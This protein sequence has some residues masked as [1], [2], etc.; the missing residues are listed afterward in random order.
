MS[1]RISF[2][3]FLCQIWVA[4]TA[5]AYAAADE[6]LQRADNLFQRGEYAEAISRYEDLLQD[7]ETQIDAQLGLAR[8]FLQKGEYERAR[9][10]C[11]QILSNVPAQPEALTFLGLTLKHTGHYKEARA[12]FERVVSTHPDHLAARLQLGIMQWQWGQKAEARRTLQH[13]IAAYQ[14][15]RRLSPK[16]IGLVA[17][18]CIYLERFR[19]ANSLFFEATKADPELWQALLPWGELMLE[20]YNTADARGIFEDALEINPNLAPGLLGLAKVARSD[21]FEAAKAAAEQALEINPNLVA[22]HDFLAELE[23]ALGRYEKALEILETPLKVNPNSLSSRSLRA[24][25]FYL[26]KQEQKYAQEES[27][28]LAINPSYGDMYYQIADVLAKRYL[29]RESVT[30]YRQALELD[31]ENWQAYAGLGTSLSRIGKEDEAKQMLEK[32]FSRD[33]YNKYVANL[34]TLFDEF[35]DYK[36]HRT[37]Y[38]TIRIHERDDAVLAP[39][40]T[41][42]AD[43]SFDEL[44]KKYEIS[45]DEEIILEIFPSH[46]DFAVRCFGLPGAQAFLGICFG[47]VVAMDSPRARSAGDFVWGET[48]W[49]ELVHVTHLRLT[50]N[51]IPRWL[52]EGIAVHETSLARPHWSMNMDW[53]FIMAF[54]NDRILPLKDLDSGFNRPTSPGQVGLSYFQASLLVEFI[55]SK[56][57]HEKILQMF[58]KFRAELETPE[59]IEAVFGKDV[60]SFDDEFR[61]YIE[62]KYKL[63]QVDYSYNPHEISDSAELLQARLADNPNNPLLNFRLGLIYQ[64]NKDYDNA[65]PYLEKAKQLFPDFVDKNNPY[66]ALADI[67]LELGQKQQAIAELRELTRRNGKHL[68]TLQLLADLCM[69]EKNYDCAAEALRKAIYISPFESDIHHTLARAYLAKEDYDAA[70]RELE[71]NLLTE[72]QDM[73]GAHCDLAEA[74]LKAGRTADAKKSALAALEIAPNYERA[75]EILLASLE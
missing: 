66:R 60:D 11:E 65:I 36:T 68:E 40:A 70:I 45:T 42:L 46:D 12:A 10:A 33:P 51:R 28:I 50:A 25:A 18:A 59:V 8:V 27:G 5:F 15:G 24:V 7:D 4:A 19:D 74:L 49:H 37:K 67:H 62:K 72:P 30:F 31:P 52:A 21:N 64:K 14:S 55:V 6:R 16:E 71:I 35:P 9:Q 57:G 17:Q 41:A 22:A 75:Q 1:R 53:P 34:L 69:Q 63:D 48:L 13:F 54:Q 61:A 56:Y 32:A 29:F 44:L 39:Y 2:L 47:N 20:K 3:L 43:R 58:P 38:L 23:I 26:L 73:A